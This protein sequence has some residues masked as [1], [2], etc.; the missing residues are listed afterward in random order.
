MSLTQAEFLTVVDNTFPDVVNVWYSSTEPLTIFGLT[1]PVIDNTDASALQ[2]LQSAQQINMFIGP[3][4]YT[5]NIISRVERT[6]FDIVYYFFDVEDQEILSTS[7]DI[8]LIP[9]QFVYFP[10]TYDNVAFSG[11]DYDIL[12]NNVE[13]SR[14]SI[15]IMVSDRNIVIGGPGSLNPVNINGLQNLTADRASVQ[16]SNYSTTGWINGRYEGSS[17]DRI[18]FAGVDSAVTG[19]TFEGSYYPS[20][21]STGSINQQISSSQVIYTQYLN[22]SEQD[23]P[24]FP[25]FRRIRYNTIPSSINATQTTIVVE[26]L[27][28]FGRFL[29][30]EVGDIIQINLQSEL[31]RVESITVVGNSRTLKVSR[32]WNGTPAQTYTAD[33]LNV[34][35][36]VGP[37]KIYQ[38]RGNKIQG[39]QKGRLVIRDSQEI[40]TIDELGQVIG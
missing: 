26:L 38:V 2:L 37:T 7:D 12:I 23:L 32:R 19:K 13:N 6:A 29:E 30:I 9:N 33:P 31:M 4:N 21:T 34:N 18:R 1:I 17:T 40:L 20:S 3:E 16:D 28:L 35:K 11:G 5:F 27:D 15:D 24:T 25:E 39:L 22:T 10:A 14:R 36:I 8:P